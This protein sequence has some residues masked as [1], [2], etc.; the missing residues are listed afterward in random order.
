MIYNDAYH[1]YYSKNINVS[2]KMK[3]K[4]KKNLI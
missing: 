1:F 4:Y 2:H 3:F